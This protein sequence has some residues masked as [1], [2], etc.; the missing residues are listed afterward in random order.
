MMELKRKGMN[1]Q[2]LTEMFSQEA[3]ARLFPPERADSFFDALFGDS[4][5]GAFDINLRY[6]GCEGAELNFELQL[7][8]RPGKCLACH[9]TRGIPEVFLRHPI[10]DINGLVRQIGELTGSREEPEWKLG[11]TRQ[12]SR[13]LHVV[14][15]TVCLAC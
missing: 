9:L 1:D 4:E 5:E 11:E 6:T 14:P 10:I 3:L 7:K 2:Q 8:E 12:V 15:L 13:Q